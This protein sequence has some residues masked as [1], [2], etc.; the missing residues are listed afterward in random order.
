MHPKKISIKEYSYDLPEGKIAHYPLAERDASR[1]L[2]Y[3][4][5]KITED[6]YRNIDMHVPENSL[7]IFNNTLDSGLIPSFLINAVPE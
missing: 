7:L 5:K 3:H 1:L 2:I 4:D 6:I